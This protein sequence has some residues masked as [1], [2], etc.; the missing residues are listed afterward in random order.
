MSDRTD[1]V[2]TYQPV[3]FLEAPYHQTDPDFE[4]VVE[5]GSVTVTL[6]T[7]QDPI[8]AAEQERIGLRVKAVFLARRLQDRRE[9]HLG[10]SPCI[11]QHEG[12]K[13]HM[14]VQAQAAEVLM[15][16]GRADVVMTD[17]AG[18][19]IRDTKAERIAADTATLDLLTAKAERSLTVRGVLDSYSHSVTDPDN[20]LVHLYEVRDAL[21]AHFGNGKAA[22]ERLGISKAEWDR[23]GSLA[24]GEIE[25]GRH[26][27]KHLAVL[28][29]ATSAELADARETVRRWIT[30]FARTV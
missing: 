11:V 15:F 20:E 1:L 13:R 4:L 7:P 8:A 12:D 18:V 21:V 10:A 22:R 17:S 2:W 29:P 6:R 23:L 9:Y 19:I 3:D 25:Q 14:T 24:N 27:G 30:T 26:R 16:G 28:R 5:G